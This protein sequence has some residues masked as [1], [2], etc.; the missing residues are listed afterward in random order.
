MCAAVIGDSVEFE[1]D[2]GAVRV[3]VLSR[4]QCAVEIIFPTRAKFM[5]ALAG[6]QQTLE[7][8]LRADAEVYVLS[9]PQAR[10]SA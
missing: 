5:N 7:N 9:L 2:G 6:A 3:R 4:G 1:N 10:E 8:A